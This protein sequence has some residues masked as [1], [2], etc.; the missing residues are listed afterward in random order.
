MLIIKNI[1]I[2]PKKIF[3]TYETNQISSG[4]YD[5]AHTW[6][7][8]NPDW[9]YCFFDKDDRRNFIKD[10]FYDKVL[11]AYDTLIPGAYKADLWRYCVLYI[12]GGVYGDIGKVL[13]T[14]LNNVL[15][16]NSS[17]ISFKDRLVDWDY[18]GYIFNAIIISKPNHPFLKKAI[19]MIVDYC[20]VGFYGHN[21][22]CP[23]GPGLLGKAI[24]LSLKRDEKSP[25]VPGKH[26]VDGIEY[27]LWPIPDFKN[28]VGYTSQRV[29][30]FLGTYSNYRK[31]LY[32][33]LSNDLSKDYQLSWFFDK[34]YSHGK[35][36]RP[37]DS[38]FHS[39]V[40]FSKV[41]AGFMQLLYKNGNKYLARKQFFIAIKKRHFR[42]R[43]VRYLIKYE[44][45]FPISKIL[46]LKK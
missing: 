10:N 21:Q 36:Y 13:L 7:D 8:K 12:Y 16:I 14:P 43:L 4:M 6:I 34:V 17:F 5:A 26:C 31:E 11:E 30:F 2:F 45:I 29:P 41:R 18:D 42:F 27:D 23:T 46:R 20:S 25:H 3:Q 38:H 1:N 37:E 44:L 22:L 39:R 28:D 15:P 35:V 40:I 32:S 9:E 19:D 33:N 24:N